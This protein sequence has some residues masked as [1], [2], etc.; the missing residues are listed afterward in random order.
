MVRTQIQLTEKQAVALKRL[1]AKK[2]V[3]MAELIRVGVNKLLHSVETVS[4]EERRQRAIAIAGR[5]R[6]GRLDL[7]TKHDEHLAEIY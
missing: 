3:S 6:S 2:R 5:F 1:A 7:S 4:L